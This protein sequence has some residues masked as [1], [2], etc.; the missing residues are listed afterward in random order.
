TEIVKR[1]TR[2]RTCNPHPGCETTNTAKF[3]IHFDKVGTGTRDGGPMRIVLLCLFSLILTATAL[4]Q[5]AAPTTA[6]KSAVAVA[7]VDESKYIVEGNI[8]YGSHPMQVL[9]MIYPKGAGPGSA[10]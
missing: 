4:A 2:G 9:D 3:G 6:P 10:A 7:K 5:S 8:A 1:S